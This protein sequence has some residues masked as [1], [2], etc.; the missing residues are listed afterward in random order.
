MRWFVGCFVIVLAWTVSARG[1]PPAAKPMPPAAEEV[2]ERMDKEVVIAKTKAVT[3]LDKILKETTKKGDLQGAMAVKE[4]ID[5]L[6]GEIKSGSGVAGG[7]VGRWK[8]PAW[9]A[10]SFPDGTIKYSH[11]HTGRWKE[12]GTTVYIE[13]DNGEMHEIQRCAEGYSGVA[14]QGGKTY[15]AVLYA[16]MNGP[17]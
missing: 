16:R 10:E 3:A 13:V 1:Q 7:F 4:A 15:C 2:L 5:R 17:Q 14:K 8:G 12:V 11:G 6:Q 9:T